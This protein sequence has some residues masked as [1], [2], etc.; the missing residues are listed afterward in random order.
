[1]NIYTKDFDLFAFQDALLSILM[2]ISKKGCN[3]LVFFPF[4]VYHVNEKQT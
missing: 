1:M 3:G 4:C 2:H